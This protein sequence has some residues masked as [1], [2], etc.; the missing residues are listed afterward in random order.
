[1]LAEFVDFLGLLEPIVRFAISDG[2]AKENGV[3]KS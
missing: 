3:M 2:C 1:M